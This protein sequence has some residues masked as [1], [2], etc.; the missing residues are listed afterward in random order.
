MATLRNL[1]LILRRRLLYENMI[2][3]TNS[4]QSQEAS[5]NLQNEEDQAA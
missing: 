2:E 1:P 5:A 3:V 4:I